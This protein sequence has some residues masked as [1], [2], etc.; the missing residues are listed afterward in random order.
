MRVNV[1]FIVLGSLLLPAAA[2]AQDA[3]YSTMQYGPR[4]SLLGG[5]VIGSVDDVSG[6]YYNP[7]ALVLASNL[8][9]SFSTNV[10]EVE[11]LRLEGR[12]G[13]GI[14][15]GSSRSGI[16]PPLSI[17]WGCRRYRMAAYWPVL[18][19]ASFIPASTASH[20]ATAPQ[21]MRNTLGPPQTASSGTAA[22]VHNPPPMKG[23]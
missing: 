1:R 5:A 8:A 20:T 9:F 16:R 12:G 6:T 4:A 15:L 7:G 22:L 10:F 18:P 23:S 13:E 14:E 21:A 11:S 19:G 2:R 17:Q 3:H